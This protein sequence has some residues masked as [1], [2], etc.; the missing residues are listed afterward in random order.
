MYA[1][2]NPEPAGRVIDAADAFPL[3]VAVPFV[4]AMVSAA[5]ELFWNVQ[6]APSVI[7]VMDAGSVMPVMPVVVIEYVVP[8]DAVV[9]VMDVPDDT[10]DK[11][12]LPFPVGPIFPHPPQ[13]ANPVGPIGPVHP[14]APCLPSIPVIPVG[15]VGAPIA[16]T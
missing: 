14:S 12:K 7:P 4:S 13:P 5:P 16:K 9:T 1:S 2:V 15:P 8:S 3:Y 6:N 11:L 10:V